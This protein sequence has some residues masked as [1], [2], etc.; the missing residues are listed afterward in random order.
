[1]GKVSAHEVDALINGPAAISSILYAR[2]ILLLPGYDQSTD[3]AQ[4]PFALSTGKLLE[5]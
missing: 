2:F 4:R 5:L 3:I 1:V